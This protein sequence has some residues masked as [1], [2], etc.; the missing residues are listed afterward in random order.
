MACRKK[1]I[2]AVAVGRNPGIYKSW[3]ECQEN[4]DSVHGAQFQSFYNMEKALNYLKAND[5]HIDNV[6]TDI[7]NH[8]TD[9]EKDVPANS[10]INEAIDTDGI[11]LDLPPI[12]NKE[13]PTHHQDQITP[14]IDIITETENYI[15]SVAQQLLLGL[16]TPIKASDTGNTIGKS[17]QSKSH[18]DCKHAI[19]KLESFFADTLLNVIKEN[20]DLKVKMI[21]GENSRL[22]TE[23]KK[24]MSEIESLK[25]IRNTPSCPKKSEENTK[26]RK[27]VD[28]STE[29]IKQLETDNRKL[30]SDLQSIKSYEKLIATKEDQITTLQNKITETERKLSKAKDETYEI[31]RTQI[32]VD[33]SDYNI[34][35]KAKKQQTYADA[36]KSLPIHQ[37]ENR[38]STSVG[39]PKRGQS[40]KTSITV[41][42][43]SHL[44][45]IDAHRLLPMANTTI[46][47]AYTLSDISDALENLQE[48][49]DCIVIHE[50]TNTIKNMS[51]EECANALYSMIK[52]YAIEFPNTHFII[53]LG[54]P[55]VGELN[56]KI[57]MVNAEIKHAMRLDNIHNLSFCDNSN[58]LRNGNIIYNLLAQDGYHL[59]QNGTSLLA[60]NIRCKVQLTLKLQRPSTS[61]KRQ[62]LKPK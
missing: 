55:R 32:A 9:K 49:P 2:Y 20:C 1:K 8:N 11:S 29:R 15:D 52:S 45:N 27:D 46:I 12:L 61:Y 38:R 19:K 31:K 44:K 17:T 40:K 13:Y 36:I 58:F 41:I 28:K 56:Y 33:T 24:L 18:I 35:Q 60:S 5:V 4:T 62:K 16:P 39:G 14:D 26:L 25:Q 50:I 7:S 3:L 34:V 22:Q 30:Q 54:L 53:S 48:D 43:N 21:T 51:A 37:H 42:G 23:N 6:V 57:E 59:S 10:N 47:Q